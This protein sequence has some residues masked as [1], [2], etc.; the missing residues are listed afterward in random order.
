MALSIV[1]F[2]LLAAGTVFTV[3][4]LQRL[5]SQ[6][7]RALASL[8]AAATRWPSVALLG[9]DWTP[10][11]LITWVIPAVILGSGALA[12]RAARARWLA[13]KALLADQ[14]PTADNIDGLKR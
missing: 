5:F 2:A 6:D 9:R 3:E 13:G 10:A 1:A 4:L 7:Y 8:N 14:H 12:A 11:S